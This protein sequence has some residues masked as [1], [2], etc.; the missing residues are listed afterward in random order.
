MYP[1]LLHREKNAQTSVE[2]QSSASK[3]AIC[4]SDLGSGKYESVNI[5]MNIQLLL[6]FVSDVENKLPKFNF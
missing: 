6:S 1:L 4:H 2:I 3:F 5:T